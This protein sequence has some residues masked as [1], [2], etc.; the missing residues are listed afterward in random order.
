MHL[1]LQ[2]LFPL[3]CHN[4]HAPIFSLPVGVLVI[5]FGMLDVQS[6]IRASSVCSAWHAL[7][8]QST[9]LNSRLPKSKLEHMK[10]LVWSHGDF[11][12]CPN[13]VTDEVLERI[14]KRYS[15]GRKSL[16]LR[17]CTKIQ[18][19][20]SVCILVEHYSTFLRFLN[21][22]FCDSVIKSRQL[23]TAIADNCP[24]LVKLSV[25][26]KSTNL[27][28][29]ECDNEIFLRLARS[30]KKLTMIEFANRRAV[31][32]RI[33]EGLAKECKHLR[34]ANFSMTFQSD[35]NAGT[36]A[37]CALAHFCKHTM[38]HL[39]LHTAKLTHWKEIGHMTY[40]EILNL[41]ETN[42]TDEEL[43]HIVSQC[44][45]LKELYAN[46][47]NVGKQFMANVSL[48]SFQL[49]S[50]TLFGC[51]NINDAAI[52][53]LRAPHQL[54]QL[55]LCNTKITNEG[56][57]TIFYRLMNVSLSKLRELNVR[58]CKMVGHTILKQLR[59]QLPD[60]M[61][62]GKEMVDATLIA[63]HR[64][65]ETAPSCF[66]YSSLQG[67]SIDVLVVVVAA[68]QKHLVRLEIQPHATKQTIE[69]K[70]P[71]ALPPRLTMHVE[72]NEEGLVM[73]VPK[74]EVRELI[75]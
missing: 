64:P 20:S 23:Y 6:R 47:T 42:V 66:E 60:A 15:C 1:H 54:R 61:I 17:G 46:G 25:S 58:C 55:N 3:K 49:R 11:A 19:P 24:N 40:L 29:D 74:A 30:C 69:P 26:A 10:H 56:V 43:A 72:I 37:L 59:E 65:S 70:V 18:N 12:L 13:N 34:T 2:R 7:I 33:L 22:N 5:I 73:N 27:L 28:G 67:R 4:N 14:V 53:C 41:N 9:E 35:Q 36:L 63:M 31:T 39:Y 57:K 8:Y 45:Q 52:E 50:L 62:A 71:R 68:T 38:K 32:A 16:N 44:Q 75:L 21:L 48:Y 51:P